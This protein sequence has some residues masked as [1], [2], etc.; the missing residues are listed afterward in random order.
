MP[1]NNYLVIG[2]N[3]SNHETN[4]DISISIKITFAKHM[5][6]STLTTSNLVLRKVNGSIV[7]CS[8]A[9]DS[10]RLQVTLQPQVN[11]ENGTQ[12]ELQI[13]GGENGIKSIT[14]DYLAADRFYEFT[15]SYQVSL[16]P[17]TSLNV[18]VDNGYP[19]VTW[20]QPVQYNPALPLTY[21]VKIST[22][23]DPLAPAIWPGQGD[24]NKTGATILNVP[25]K[26]EEG[27]YYAYVRAENSE[28][29]SD[30]ASFQFAVVNTTTPPSGEE[31]NPGFVF[32]VVETYPKRD[33]VDITPEKIY[34]LFSD[35]VDETTIHE[36][37]VYIVKGGKENLSYFDFLTDYSPSKKVNA[38]IDPITSPTNMVSITPAT[39]AL[40]DDAEYTVV[41]RETVKDKNGSALGAAYYWSFMTKF[42]RL[43]GDP[44]MIRSDIGSFV[45][46]LSDKMI[47][48]RL[49]DISQ[50][51]Y[52]VVSQRDDFNA[53]DY[54]N[55]KAPYYVHKYVSYQAAY[56]LILN[57]Y[58][59]Q[60]SGM[61]SSVS[62]G[63]LTVDKKSG[64][65]NITSILEELK[66][67]MKPWEDLLHGHH[68]RGYAKPTIA[69]KGETGAPY[70]EFLTR[71]EF[72]ELGQ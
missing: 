31:P 30:W 36:N 21:E 48:K 6:V 61:G 43:Y 39:G 49:R 72:Q 52:D 9:Y 41:I 64:E 59:Q 38:T 15:T 2:V 68:N 32:E 66:R 55:G 33:A 53:S 14:G 51:A 37:T 24:V 5:D 23:S 27:N 69:V 65:V 26:L 1:I 34:I 25:K 7:T 44:E 28:G 17:P 10:D 46:N 40:E 50:Y 47:Y 42:T 19:T 11:L 45:I 54:E 71:T 20:S 22:S 29:I 60:S 3:P 8:I 4:V 12:Y 16:S 62:L 13:V 57:G 58:L 70:P 63:D 18:T 56:D 35:N 67:R